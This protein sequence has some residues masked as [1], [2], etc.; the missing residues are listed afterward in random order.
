MCDTCGCQ[1]EN[2]V[3]IYKPDHDH[4][5]DLHNQVVPHHHH[6]GEHKHREI[7]VEQDI[8]S[9]NNLLA[10]RNRGFFEALGIVALNMV[11]SPGSG[12]T[13]V[14]ERTISEM[15]SQLN[16]FIIEG[17]QQ[18]ANDAKRIQKAGGNAIQVNT[19]NGCHLDAKMVNDALK[20]LDIKNN[21]VL[22][23]VS[24]THLRAH[25]T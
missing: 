8:L 12:K 17:D 23:A 21:S 4:R 6:H 20:P 14:I 22:I 11:S 1:D 2:N 25:E 24:Y 19:G 18:T 16:F 9:K 10:E 7:S 5:H 15:G 13:S 3:K